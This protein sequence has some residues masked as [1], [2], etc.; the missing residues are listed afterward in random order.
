MERA[1]RPLGVDCVEQL[2][3]VKYAYCM[4]WQGHQDDG[5]ATELGEA[6]VRELAVNVGWSA[7][8][9]DVGF[10]L[11]RERLKTYAL[12]HIDGLQFAGSTHPHS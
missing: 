10:G 3:D 7:A 4:F 9:A 11:A 12:S 1:D 2:P 6:T 8:V 5:K